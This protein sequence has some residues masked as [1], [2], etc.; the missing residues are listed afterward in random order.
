MR[1]SVASWTFAVT[2]VFALTFVAC[3]SGDDDDDDDFQCD[4]G[5]DE[6][7][8]GPNSPMQQAFADG[9]C[10]EFGI[11]GC[12]DRDPDLARREIEWRCNCVP[13][14]CARWKE[15]FDRMGIEY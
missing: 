15:A 5:Q 12:V 9:L 6:N 1:K 7:P 4:F 2:A 14:S 11:Q 13:D 3:M 8:F 10:G